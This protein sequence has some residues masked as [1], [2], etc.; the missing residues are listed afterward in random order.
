MQRQRPPYQFRFK[1]GDAKKVQ[2]QHGEQIRIGNHTSGGEKLVDGQH[3][4]PLA[5]QC[6]Q[7]FVGKTIG[8]TG[9]AH[10]QVARG[11]IRI[12]AEGACGQRVRFAHDAHVLAV[13]HP[14]VCKKNRVAGLVASGQVSHHGGKVTDGQV[15]GLLVQQVAR[16]AGGQWHYA[17][18][19]LRR[20]SCQNAHQ[21][22]HQGCGSRVGHGQNKTVVGGKRIKFV[23]RK[24]GF[25]L[26]QRCLHGRPESLGVRR[27]LQRAPAATQQIV[28]QGFAQTPQGVADRRLRKR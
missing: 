3:N 9:I 8:A 27:R 24:R 7:G 28:A 12:Q 6:G 2:G 16:V 5:A 11:A 25:Q 10:Q 4:A 26:P 13:V 22:R 15:G 21:L 1:S 17:H 18:R 23:W 20:F 14:L 19:H